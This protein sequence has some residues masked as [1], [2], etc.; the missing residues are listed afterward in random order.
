[1]SP[2]SN[3][4]LRA[5]ARWRAARSNPWLRSRFE[6]PMRAVPLRLM[7]NHRSDSAGMLVKT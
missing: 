7:R 1:M 5:G 6:A 4:T 2:G 3:S